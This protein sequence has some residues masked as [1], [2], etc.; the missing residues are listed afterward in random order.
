MQTGGFL[1]SG[2]F[3]KAKF[4]PN[5]NNIHFK[6]S[7]KNPHEPQPAADGVEGSHESKRNQ[8]PKPTKQVWHPVRE[9][10]LGLVHE[11]HQHDENAQGQHQRQ[12]HHTGF[13]EQ[14]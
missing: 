3:E 13:I 11:Q 6:R 8:R 14:G 12:N 1:E 10:V 4:C 7:V 9:V 2:A 5:F